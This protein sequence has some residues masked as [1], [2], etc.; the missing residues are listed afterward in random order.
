MDLRHGISPSRVARSVTEVTAA[1]QRV[2]LL[3]VGCASAKLTTELQSRSQI[4][5]YSSPRL[6]SLLLS[7]L[8]KWT[9]V[10]T[11]QIFCCL[12]PQFMFQSVLADLLNRIPLRVLRRKGHTRET[13]KTERGVESKVLFPVT[14][15]PMGQINTDTEPLHKLKRSRSPNTTGLE[16]TLERTEPV[17]DVN[18][19]WKNANI[20]TT[21][22]EN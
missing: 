21:T 5:H 17:L 14:Q 6:V 1:S 9:P 8:R 4:G 11:V 19:N 3:D 12:H 20:S 16:F 15:L 10:G 2:P 18:L 7:D 22:Q 13:S